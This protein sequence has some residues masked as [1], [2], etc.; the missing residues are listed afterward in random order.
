MGEKTADKRGRRSRPD[1]GR[2]RRAL[3]I[4]ALIVAG[5]ILFLALAGEPS[6]WPSPARLWSRTAR[7]LLRSVLFISVGLLVGQLI[8][9]LG[10]TAKLGRAVWPL[11][12]WARLPGA[13]GAAFT[14]AF[15]SG[16]LAN[17]MLFTGWQNGRLTRKGLILS[18][19]LNASL[20]A[21]VLHMPTT[22]FIVVSL[23]GRAGLWYIILTFAAAFIRF[24]GVIAV[25]RAVMPHCDA[26]T[27]EPAGS[28]KGW[29]EVWRETWP[30]FRTRLGRMVLIIIP[31]YLA[32]A[33]LAESGFF[34]RLQ[35]LLA[36]WVSS[37][38]I[39][40]EA[41]GL[42]VFSAAAEFTSG[43]V[44]AGALLESGALAVRDVVLAL[45][46]GNVVATPLRTLRHQLPHY[47]GIY[48]PRLGAE[49]LLIGQTVRV[50]SVVLAAAGFA[51]L[52]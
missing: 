34:D 4:A 24:L 42:I 49:M 35:M 37:S 15:V 22:M 2:G 29:A 5:L 43:F 21:Y 50:L 26:C 1:Q 14:S 23:T 11:I 27:Y 46:I 12:N 45:L 6:G 30:K 33:A 17:T 41:M 16:V 25:S 13:S 38:V 40:V 32:V 48:S 52:Y 36:R 44:A 10:W 47:M 20:P 9:A 19:L 51:W 8:E 7:P 3:A 28:K 31:V 39:P 18:N